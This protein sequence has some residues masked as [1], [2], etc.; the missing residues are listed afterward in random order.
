MET[1]FNPFLPFQVRRGGQKDC[2]KETSSASTRAIKSKIEVENGTENQ[3]EVTQRNDIS[4]KKTDE[5]F[6]EEIREDNREDIECEKDRKE[7]EKSKENKIYSA[8]I[9]DEDDLSIF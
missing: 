6:G 5:M 9:D 7:T 1:I 3:V 2:E 8:L 4:G